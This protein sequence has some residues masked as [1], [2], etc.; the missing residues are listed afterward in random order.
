MP[1]ECMG[2]P[3]FKVS[4]FDKKIALARGLGTYDE[5]P[6]SPNAGEKWGTPA[7]SPHSSQQRA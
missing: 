6:T 4:K 2:T 7:T 5:Y 1:D 3:G